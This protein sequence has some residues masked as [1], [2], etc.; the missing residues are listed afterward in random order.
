MNNLHHLDPFVYQI[1]G[2]IH[3]QE[4]RQRSKL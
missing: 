1:M 2:G 4:F 3:I